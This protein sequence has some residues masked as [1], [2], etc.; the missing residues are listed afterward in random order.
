MNPKPVPWAPETTV[1]PED[2]VHGQEL[3]KAS[4]I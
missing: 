3:G 4:N 2:P 1:T